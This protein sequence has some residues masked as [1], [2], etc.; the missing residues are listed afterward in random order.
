VDWIR[1]FSRA[2]PLGVSMIVGG[3]AM[4]LVAVIWAL[5]A[6]PF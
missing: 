3:V 5:V 4:V 1:T 6:H 2:R